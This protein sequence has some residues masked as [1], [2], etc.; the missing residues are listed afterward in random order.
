M[1]TNDLVIKPVGDD[2]HIL[3]VADAHSELVEMVKYSSQLQ[4]APDSFG[5]HLSVEQADKETLI[6][7]V[8]ETMV[9]ASHAIEDKHIVFDAPVIIKGAAVAPQGS[10]AL[11]AAMN[12][13]VKDKQEAATGK[14]D[15]PLAD[16]RIQQMFEP[17]S[18]PDAKPK[19]QADFNS[20]Q[21][22][23]NMTAKRSHI[24]LT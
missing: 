10:I 18:D 17:Q 13:G 19:E 12:K 22:Q 7:A 3:G 5:L 2:L 15:I 21:N 4:P 14:K 8:N 6:R 16:P 24:T 9:K 23:T 1:A 20:S 11:S